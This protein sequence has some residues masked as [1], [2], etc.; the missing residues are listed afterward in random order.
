MTMYAQDCK[1]W[2]PVSRGTV[3]QTGN[4]RYGGIAG[5]FSYWQVGDNA[6]GQPNGGDGFTGLPGQATEETATDSTGNK[7]PA[8]RAYMDGF[9]VLFCPSDKEDY[10]FAKST[11][12]HNQRIQSDR[13][14]QPKAP[15]NSRDVVGYNISYMYIVG[16]KQDEPVFA[17]PVPFYGDEMLGFDLNVNAF[18]DNPTDMAYA[19][20][21]QKGFYGK[22][23][24]HGDEGGEFTF[25]DG[26]VEFFKGNI[27]EDIF[28]WR[29]RP[30]QANN[31]APTDGLPATP[32][33]NLIDPRRSDRV[34][35]LE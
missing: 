17:K 25:S 14:R 29:F 34:E 24:N 9:G 28:G 7:E 4:Y 18:Y 33:I 27:G 31:T 13:V 12:N 32:G 22:K 5:F 30:G 11:T 19:G 10:W 15:K 2:Y 1:D 16:L 3:P 23:D 35:T 26:H 21:R 20:S 8:L 6:F